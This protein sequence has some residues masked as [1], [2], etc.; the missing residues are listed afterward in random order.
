MAEV[1]LVDGYNVLHQSQKLLHLVRQDM[2]TAR[3]AFID[4]VAHFCI[5]TGK[6]VVVVFDG[7]GPQV[8]QKVAHNRSVPSL[9]VLYSPGHLTAD[10]VIDTEKDGCG[11]GHER[12][13]RAGS[14]PGHGRS[15]DGRG[16]F[17]EQSGRDPVF[18][19]RDGDE[20]AQARTRPSGRAT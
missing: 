4:K 17:S 14:L 11:G 9:E 19:T 15:G 18:D 12:S 13:G 20:Y 10:A 1:H 2:E 8:I 5:Q 3:E 7:R 16:E 6:H